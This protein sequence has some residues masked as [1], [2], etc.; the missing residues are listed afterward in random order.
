[1]SR[2]IAVWGSAVGLAALWTGAQHGFHVATMTG[3][4]P[5]HYGY[6]AYAVVPLVFL[7]PLWLRGLAG[8]TL[9]LSGNRAA[10]VGVLAGLAWR[11]VRGPHAGTRALLLAALL[12]LAVVAGNALKPRGA[13]GDHV[14]LHIWKVAL[15]T[16]AKHPEGV[17]PGNFALGVDGYAVTKAHSDVLQLLVERG[18]RVTGAV[19]ALAVFAVC[20]L[21]AGAPAT[22]AVVALA[23]QSL[24][25]NRLHHPACGALLAA[26]WICAWRSRLPG[27]PTA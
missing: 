5:P 14:R 9:L 4:L 20:I 1:M 17:G 11:W 27:E 2:L 22:A 6:S 24:I 13:T 15:T 10:W 16:A 12:P 21:P 18:F 3:F 19:L 7:G 26:V 25:D 23:S 8:A